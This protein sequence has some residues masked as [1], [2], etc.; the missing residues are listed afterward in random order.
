MM[1]NNLKEAE[2]FRDIFFFYVKYLCNIWSSI[3]KIQSTNHYKC[4]LWND[5]A[6]NV[7]QNDT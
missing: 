7:E 5:S 2:L 6:L 1:Y 4:I 3:S